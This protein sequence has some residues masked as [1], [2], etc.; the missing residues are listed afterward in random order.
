MKEISIGSWEDFDDLMVSGGQFSAW[1]FRGQSDASW[2]IHSSLS[3]HLRT[4]DV[5]PDLWPSQEARIVR[6]FKRKA[7]L[8]LDHVPDDDDDFQWLSLIQHYG[9]PTRLLDFTWSPYVAAYFALELARADSAVFAVNTSLFG[10]T[11][12]PYQDLRRSGLY[13]SE[14]LPGTNRIVAQGEPALLNRR[15]TAQHGTF[16]VP[17]VID[18]P[19]EE[20][21]E[22]VFGPDSIVKLVLKHSIRQL[23]MKSLYKRCIENAT[24][25]PDLNGLAGSLRYELEHH[26]AYD[27]RTGID[28]P[29][30]A[31]NPYA[32]I[33]ETRIN[34]TPT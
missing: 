22:D 26:W 14:Y 27:A 17:G 25:F 20:L 16:V 29:H 4:F 30:F 18:V 12:L 6:I 34:E 11:G 19:L 8:Y 31:G 1:A 3:R 15:I 10:S 32:K 2:S 13:R 7:H 33:L 5:Y 23:A 21:L 24:L 28:H 9:G